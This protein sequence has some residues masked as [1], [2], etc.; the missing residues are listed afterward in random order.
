M[1]AE[2]AS[3]YGVFIGYLYLVNYILGTG[4]LGIPYV[5]HHGGTIAGCLTLL[6]ISFFSCLTSIWTLETISRAQAIERT[7]SAQEEEVT[8][9]LIN[10]ED[11][12]ASY[13]SIEQYP[14]NTTNN[15]IISYGQMSRR[16][17]EITELCNLF[18]GDKAKIVYMLVLFVYLALA[19]WSFTTVAASTWSSN[20]PFGNG[21]SL[22]QCT[23]EDFQDRI[24][25]EAGG[26][27]NSYRLCA[28]IF[29]VIVLSLS[30]L[31]VTEQKII[32][33]IMGILRFVVVLFMCFNSV[34]DLTSKENKQIPFSNVSHFELMDSKHDQPYTTLTYSYTNPL[35]YN[36]R[37]WVQAIPVFVYAQVLHQGIPILIE[38]VTR[39]QHLRTMVVAVFLTMYTLYTFLGIVISYRFGDKVS[40]ISTLNWSDFTKPG[41][42]TSL[43]VMS[44]LVVFFPSL[45]VVSVFPMVAV[46]L[47]NNIFTV[48]YGGDTT[49]VTNMR[50]PRLKRVSMRLIAAALPIIGG[51]FVESLVAVLKYAGLLGFLISYAFPIILQYYSRRQYKTAFKNLQY[52][53]RK[54]PW[55]RSPATSK[56]VNDDNEELDQSD[57]QH[58]QDAVTY[59]PPWDTPYS[60]ILSGRKM[61]HLSAVY[62]I[63]VFSLTIVGIA[64]P[65]A[66]SHKHSNVSAISS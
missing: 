57:N 44:Y 24:I 20:I 32:Q 49:T 1:P 28:G 51:L 4:F 13:D 19:C 29:A 39:K 40:Q 17:F 59:Q 31:E 30:C 62:T 50:Y 11:C 66:M 9:K 15:N 16:K 26:C 34:A 54:K 6:T 25:P 45:D 35:Y 2:E 56:S 42:P 27:L 18:L 60:T 21:S 47:G 5:I 36:F 8:K 46:T 23:Q 53:R 41:N 43:R 14:N 63:A 10:A 37:A 52:D 58:E 64:L 3:N 65:T 38:P 7:S 33:I 55:D 61:V 12:Q 48:L 22:R